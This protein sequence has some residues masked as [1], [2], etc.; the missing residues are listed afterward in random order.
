MCETSGG[1]RERRRE[2]GIHMLRFMEP[3]DFR[4]RSAA[5]VTQPELSLG[6]EFLH[7]TLRFCFHPLPA[8]RPT[9]QTPLAFAP[10]SCL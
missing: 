8:A 6:Q 10:Y 2:F 1:G 7:G 3:Q 9:S 5:G 4:V